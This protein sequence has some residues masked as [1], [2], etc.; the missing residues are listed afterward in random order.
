MSKALE[1]RY[2]LSNLHKRARGGE[3]RGYI[4]VY[5]GVIGVLLPK[6]VN[7]HSLFLVR[8]RPAFKFFIASSSSST[9]V[10][11]SFGRLTPYDMQPSTICEI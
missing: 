11:L 8:G 2:E 4:H 6:A 3:E 5:P 7:Q 10:Q 9:Q 1:K